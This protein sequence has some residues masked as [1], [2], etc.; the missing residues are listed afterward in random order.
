MDGGVH[1][2]LPRFRSF[3]CSWAVCF[4]EA[5]IFVAALY[6]V[7]PTIRILP[8]NDKRHIRARF[9]SITVSSCS[10]LLLLYYC[11]E[12]RTDAP[13]F[14]AWV[15][16]RS[17]NC[18][19]ATFIPLLLTTTL[20]LGTLVGMVLDAW[21]SS[22]HELDRFG[23]LRLREKKTSFLS[24]LGEDLYERSLL[25]VDYHQT[26]RNF[27]MGPVS[28]ELVF[29]GCMFPLLI[30]SGASYPKIVFLSPFFFGVAHLHHMYELTR[31]GNPVMHAFIAVL[32]QFSYTYLFG[33]FAGFIYLR[34]GHLWAAI[35]C[36]IFCNFMGLPDF[37]FM[38]KGN[39]SGLSILYQYRY[40]LMGVYILGICLFTTLLFPLTDPMFYNSWLWYFRATGRRQSVAK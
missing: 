39:G 32:F 28:E 37:S 31:Q 29:R 6:L 26:L 30:C 18:F 34:T 1:F 14:W 40:V 25:S 19:L 17:E 33:V 5:L 10:A 3:S 23:N 22:S 38:F 15:G 21:V 9:L 20:F 24:R 12:E 16:F 36:H 2:P 7:P 11:S 4:F 13:C 35:S 8:R 27:L